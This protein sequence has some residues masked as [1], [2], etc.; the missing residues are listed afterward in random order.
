[1]I[2]SEKQTR[3]KVRYILD[4]KLTERFSYEESAEWDSRFPPNV[5]DADPLF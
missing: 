4:H 1:M 5:S 2:G 3:D